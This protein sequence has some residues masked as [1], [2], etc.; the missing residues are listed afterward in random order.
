MTAGPILRY[1]QPAIEASWFKNGGFACPLDFDSYWKPEA[2]HSMNKLCTDDIQQLEYYRTQGYFSSIPSVSADLSDIVSGKKPG[3]EGPEERI[4]SLNLGLAIE[5][6]ATAMLIY[7][8]AKRANVGL[9]LP[10]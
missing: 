5:D 4:M 10:L 7:L 6:I 9:E 3:R 8:K 1:P 2:I